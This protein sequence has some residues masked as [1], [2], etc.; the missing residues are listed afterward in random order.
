M[1]NVPWVRPPTGFVKRPSASRS[2]GPRCDAPGGSIA[3][4]PAAAVTAQAS[5]AVRAAIRRGEREEIT[6]L[7]APSAEPGGAAVRLRPS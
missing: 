1:P 6:W 7:V 3:M 2:E 5:A 4:L